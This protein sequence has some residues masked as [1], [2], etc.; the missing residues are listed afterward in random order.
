MG[1]LEEPTFIFNLDFT[2]NRASP[3]SLYRYYNAEYFGFPVMVTTKNAI[4]ESKNRD[5]YCLINSLGI[6]HVGTKG[7]KALARHY[8][9]MDKLMKANYTNLSLVDEYHSKK[10]TIKRITT[11]FIV[12]I[13]TIVLIFLGYYF[14]NSYNTI[15]VFKIRGEN[16]HFKTYNGIMI[17]TKQ[18]NYIRIGELIKNNETTEI[19][20]LK[21]Y[22][23]DANKKEKILYEDNKTDILII[24]RYGYDKTFVSNEINYFIDNLYLEIIY[25]NNQKDK[26]KLK[27]EKDFANS[28]NFN[29]NFDSITNDINSPE[30][31]GPIIYE[32]V[33]TKMEQIGTKEGDTYKLTI[34]NPEEKIEITTEENKLILKVTKDNIKTIWNCTFE[35]STLIVYTKLT[36]DIETDSTIV[37]INKNATLTPA[38]KDIYDKLTNYITTYILNR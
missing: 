13:L 17:S 4:E 3:N 6:R 23:L 29:K 12:I 35:Y 28:F 20:S 8:K 36:E 7:A 10:K 19:K 34:D 25:D 30:D 32:K 2:S 24:S 26:I 37:T 21:L 27:V 11:T 38:Q 22:Y 14:V 16:D 9:T 18:K 5:L 33:K 1:Q 31:S 15:N